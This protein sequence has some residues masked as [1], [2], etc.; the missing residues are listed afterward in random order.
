MNGNRTAVGKSVRQQGI[1][2]DQLEAILSQLEFIR[3]RREVCELD[4][5]CVRVRLEPWQGY[6]FRIGHSTDGMILL[7]N[8]DFQAGFCQIAGTGQTVMPAADHDGVIVGW[9]FRTAQ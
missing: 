6:F 4:A 9:H 2:M 3:N 8:E 7:Q 1:R 5:Y